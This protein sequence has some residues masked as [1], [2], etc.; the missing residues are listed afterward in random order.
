M[1]LVYNVL[2]VATRSSW[3]GD[4]DAAEIFCNYKIPESLQ[5]YAGFDVYWAEKG[6]VLRW[7]RWNSTT[8]V[9]VSPPLATIRIFYWA[10]E[11]ITGD[12]KNSLNPLFWYIIIQNSPGT[13]SYDPTTP[14]IYRLDSI[15][16]VMNTACKTYFD[17]LQSIVATQSLAKE[18]THQVYTPM[19]YLGL[20]DATSKRR[21]ISQTTGEWTG[22]ITLSLEAVGLF[23]M[24]S[25]K[26]WNKAKE[27]IA[28]IFITF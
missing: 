15:R 20:Q 28:K 22:Y 11:L 8:M 17:N 21:P 27:M 2:D 3:F 14:R 24:V 18:A 7:E 1:L 19:V 4:I 25:E 16:G 12:R 23:I 10:M 26:K 5:K 13:N 9:S 6:N